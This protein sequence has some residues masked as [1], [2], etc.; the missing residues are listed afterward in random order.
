[1]SRTI[2][3]KDMVSRSYW[4][5]LKYYTNREVKFGEFWVKVEFHPNT[6][7]YKKGLALYTR[8]KS[9]SCNKEPG[10][11]WFRN[12]TVERPLRRKHKNELRKVKMNWQYEPEIIAKGKLKYW[13]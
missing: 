5:A 7:G 12:L 13:T 6:D 9:V 4:N 8:D 11:K 2:R 1:M 10:P 3:R